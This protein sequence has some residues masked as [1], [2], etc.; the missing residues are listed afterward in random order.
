MYHVPLRCQEKENTNSKRQDFQIRSFVQQMNPIYD[1]C[2]SCLNY[3]RI[4]VTE[5][6]IIVFIP[7]NKVNLF[8][9]L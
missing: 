6:N 9:R 3:H 4:I 1:S 5:I 8:L 7:C 2:I